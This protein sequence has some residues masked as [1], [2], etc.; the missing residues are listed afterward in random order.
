MTDSKQ[1]LKRTIIITM[2][3]GQ[4]YKCTDVSFLGC[5]GLMRIELTSGEKKSI[6]IEDLRV[7]DID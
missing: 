7:L 6:K 4:T 1:P 2:D 5:K 3:S